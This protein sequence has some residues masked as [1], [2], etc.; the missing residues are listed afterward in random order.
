MEFQVSFVD[1]PDCDG[2]VVCLDWEFTLL[3]ICVSLAHIL[4]K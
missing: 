4:I 3:C 1:L 2:F